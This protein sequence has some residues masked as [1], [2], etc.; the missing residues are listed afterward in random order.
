MNKKDIR[1]D[2]RLIRECLRDFEKAMTDG[3]AEEMTAI[4][5]ELIGMACNFETYAYE[6]TVDKAVSDFCNY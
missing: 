4:A 5:S 6:V 1:T 3:N 2:A